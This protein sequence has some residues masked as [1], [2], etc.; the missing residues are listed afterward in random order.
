MEQLREINGSTVDSDFLIKINDTDSDFVK[1]VKTYFEA[2][3]NK[4]FLKNINQ[5][6]ERLLSDNQI[7]KTF[8]QGF[9][10]IENQDNI[11]KL[12]KAILLTNLSNSRNFS[13]DS[14]KLENISGNYSTSN[15]AI[16]DEITAKYESII[17]IKNMLL[18]FCEVLN[19]EKSSEEDR[20]NAILGF[21]ENISLKN[22]DGKQIKSINVIF[23]NLIK[24]LNVLQIQ[25]I[26]EKLD[27]IKLLSEDSIIDNGDHNN[28]N[29]KY[30]NNF[31]M[32]TSQNSLKV[33]VVNEFA[34][35]NMLNI[36]MIHSTIDALSNISNEKNSLDLKSES[37]RPL[38]EAFIKCIKTCKNNNELKKLFTSSLNLL[39]NANISIRNSITLFKNLNAKQIVDLAEDKTFVGIIAAN[40]KTSN[41]NYERDRE[42]NTKLF[43]AN[44][45]MKNNFSI[46]NIN[47]II[48][49]DK[50][51]DS[52]ME[53][54]GSGQEVVK[55]EVE[56]IVE[57]AKKELENKAK[58]AKKELENK[59]KQAK[60]ELKNKAKQ[61]KK[62][63]KGK[64]T[65]IEINKT[66][67]YSDNEYK[68][69]ELPSP[70]SSLNLKKNADSSSSLES[71]DEDNYRTFERDDFSKSP[72]EV[73]KNQYNG[74][75]KE[76]EGKISRSNSVHV[77][78]NMKLNANG[79][80]ISI[81]NSG[82][83]G[84]CSIM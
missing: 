61:A 66:T 33:I 54:F 62:E 11:N 15:L 77:S 35:N 16:N 7:F 46:K 31:L 26:F 47:Y 20:F 18:D 53:K 39:K 1:S 37:Y 30:F 60:K 71:L 4:D 24:E 51:I 6:F 19:K 82:N 67:S 78:L 75:G 32:G 55:K 79:N 74:K 17:A 21:S 50:A 29:T 57:Q 48:S 52:F 8:N 28:Y 68:N 23:Q 12:L 63:V 65:L 9:S 13:E 38:I 5:S 36:E 49:S 40:S 81:N 34:K 45:L 27:I 41:D 84:G 76:K 80:S 44:E 3:K 56:I 70:S 25:S 73:V 22:K 43:I 14:K 83:K 2:L 58:Q 10:V 42:K 59:A 72:V 64:T 69:I